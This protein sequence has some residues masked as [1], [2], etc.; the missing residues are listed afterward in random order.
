M[1]NDVNDT[2]APLVE[3][4]VTTPE[5]A[6]EQEEKALWAD[7]TDDNFG[8][9]DDLLDTLPD[10]P[11]KA[12]ALT[13]PEPS[14]PKTAVPA[15]SVP[16]VKPDAE[17]ATPAPSTVVTP[18]VVE[19]STA[20]ANPDNFQEQYS[21]WFTR[22]ADTLSK[23]L[24]QITDEDAEAITLGDAAKVKETFARM[25]GNLHMQVLVAAVT[26]AANMMPQMVPQIV[27]NAT[28]RDTRVREFYETYQELRGH[29]TVVDAI[30]TS[31]LQAAPT[32]D[33]KELT[34]RI[35][36]AAAAT[37]GVTPAAL[38]NTTSSAANSTVAPPP[39]PAGAARTMSRPAPTK[40]EWEEMLELE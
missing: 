9:Q 33:R 5:P 11:V 19:A 1:E 7:I 40:T 4:T 8:E 14:E 15:E 12:A 29:E 2:T 18:P 38:R 39:A 20:T 26:Q 13:E 3:E 30:A 6:P 17:E 36:A 27:Q 23:E 37:V 31:M 22:S 21:Q 16:E 35:A 32:L 10:E 24:Y 25:A 28:E 34:R